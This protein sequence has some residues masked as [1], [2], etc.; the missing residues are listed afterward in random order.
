MLCPHAHPSGGDASPLDELLP[1]L[2]SRNDVDLQI[3]AV[4]AIVVKELL[5][6]W[7][8]KVTADQEFVEEIISII[9]HCTRALESRLRAVDLES[10]VLDEIAELV[11]NHVHG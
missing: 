8:G 11:E 9:A 6:S 5:Y 2:T 10:L 1:P 4:I 7:Y 3:Y